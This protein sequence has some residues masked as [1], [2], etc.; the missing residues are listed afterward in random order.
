MV[1][2]LN[3][4][5][6]GPLSLLEIALSFVECEKLAS[7]RILIEFVESVGQFGIGVDSVDH[8]QDRFF[9]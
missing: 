6:D 9:H 5:G 4:A 1:G 3:E 7:K 2:V 8:A